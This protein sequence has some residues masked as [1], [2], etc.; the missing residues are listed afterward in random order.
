MNNRH[1]ISLIILWV[2]FASLAIYNLWPDN[3]H[4]KERPFPY[5]VY[6]YCIHHIHPDKYHGAWECHLKTVEQIY[7]LTK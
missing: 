4:N 2:V 1:K 5:T 3:Q 6:R 7:S